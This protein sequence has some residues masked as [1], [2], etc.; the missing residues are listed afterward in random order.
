MTTSGILVPFEIAR[1]WLLPTEKFRR[2]FKLATRKRVKTMEIE[3]GYVIKFVS[4]EDM[5]RLEI[6]QRLRERYGDGAL[7][8]SQ[9]YSWIR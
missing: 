9:I 1:T 7:S 3:R 4:D 5:P 8:Q 2:H 6:V